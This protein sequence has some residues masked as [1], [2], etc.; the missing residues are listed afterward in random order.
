MYKSLE[1]ARKY[2]EDGKGPIL[3]EAVTYRKGAHTTS[4]DPTKYRTEEEEQEWDKKDPLRRLQSYLVSKGLWDKE[5]EKKLIDQYKE[6]IDRIFVEAENYPAYPLE[7]A[8]KY[9][10]KD[11]PSD[12]FHQKAAH[13]KFLKS[14]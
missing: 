13:E 6:E 1:E 8:F 3:I 12:L 9:M 4:D 2:C 5:D 11:I 7:D 10:Y 14:R